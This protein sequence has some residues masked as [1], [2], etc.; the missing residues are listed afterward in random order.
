MSALTI[1]MQL[2]RYAVDEKACKGRL[3]INDIY[4]C[5]TIEPPFRD[6]YGAIPFGVYTVKLVWS[7]KFKCVVPYI[8]IEGRSGIEFHTGN[9][10]EQSKGCILVGYN[11]P[12][13]GYS[14]M[15]SKVAFSVLMANLQ[16]GDPI[17][18]LYITYDSDF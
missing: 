17:I 9:I 12:Y 16:E 4:V 3:F 1:K 7:S 11:R 15:Y 5:D 18:N 6:K 10:P 13:S 2:A 14:V 8:L